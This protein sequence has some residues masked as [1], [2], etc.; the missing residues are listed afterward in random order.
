MK[1]RARMVRAGHFLGIAAML[2]CGSGGERA[3][4]EP[5]ASVPDASMPDGSTPGA[6]DTRLTWKKPTLHASKPQHVELGEDG[7]LVNGAPFFVRGAGY[8]EQ[9]PEVV[10]RGGNSVRTWGEAN[11]RTTLDE[12]QK[13]GLLVAV[14]L[15]V[16]HPSKDYDYTKDAVKLAQ[17]KLHEQAIDRYK[18]DPA[19]LVWGIGNEVNFPYDGKAAPLD[20]WGVIEELAAYAHGVDPNHPVMSVVTDI[21]PELIAVIKER[22]PSLDLLG[23]NSYEGLPTL[24]QRLRDAGWDKP[25]L[26]T[27]W[28]GPGAWAAKKTPWNAALELSSGEKA[29]SFAML[30]DT[31]VA[32]ARCFGSYAFAWGTIVAPTTTWFSMFDGR[33]RPTELV[34]AL[35]HAWTGSWPAQRAATVSA[36]TLN[37]ASF[38]ETGEKTLHARVTAQPP[39]GQ[40]LTYGWQIRGDRPVASPDGVGSMPPLFASV[41]SETPEIDLAV[42]PRAGSYRVYVTASAAQGSVG[43]A[44]A[45]FLV[46]VDRDPPPDGDPDARFQLGDFYDGAVSDGASRYAGPI[47]SVWDAASLF[48]VVR[49]DVAEGQSAQRVTAGASGWLGFGVSYDKPI[50]VRA[51]KHLHVSL[52]SSVKTSEPLLTVTIGSEKQVAVKQGASLLASKYGFHA[53]GKWHELVIPLADFVPAAPAGLPLDLSRLMLGFGASLSKAEP[54]ATV[55]VDGLYLSAQ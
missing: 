8:L 20:V 21:T 16:A 38:V 7:F 12:A 32:D 6:L 15:Y 44:N 30:H 35:Q 46:K 43:V 39:D 14:G 48:S 51:W 1:R 22:A 47:T 13:L 29:A 25:Y 34:D 11:A 53:D 28:S 24:P 10:A 42:P 36:L 26:V 49:D 54:G 31:L 9:L 45:P 3:R 40:E 52:R 4:R 2:A 41:T 18:D 23:I 17:L 37:D 27:E 55:D 33:G 50:D 5:E 19:L